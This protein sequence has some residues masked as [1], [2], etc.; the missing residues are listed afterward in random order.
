MQKLEKNVKIKTNE[1]KK[2]KFAKFKHKHIILSEKVVINY[3]HERQIVRL[4][5]KVI[6]LQKCN[7]EM[8][9]HSKETKQLH[10]LKIFQPNT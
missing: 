5:K 10:S 2:Q 8:H 1:K 3:L 9:T 4:R 6:Q 7:K